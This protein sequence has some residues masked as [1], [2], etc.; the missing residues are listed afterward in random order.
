MPG[1]KSIQH[2]L[3]LWDQEDKKNN[4]KNEENNNSEAISRVT[5][6]SN[7]ASS[8][9]AYLIKKVYVARQSPLICLPFS[10]DMEIM[11]VINDPEEADR[12]IK[13]HINI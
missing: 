2:A 10:S 7:K 3:H 13:Y 11:A 12:I 4:S 5:V 6:S 1:F 9:W 8:T